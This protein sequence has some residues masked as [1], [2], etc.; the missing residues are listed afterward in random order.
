[1]SRVK[2]GN[3]FVNTNKYDNSITGPFKME[4]IHFDGEDYHKATTLS[5]WIFM[6]YDMS[7]KTFKHKSKKRRNE[8]REEFNNDTGRINYEG[9]ENYCKNV[10]K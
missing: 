9:H 1:M 7:Y 2:L 8:L 4:R 5:Q 10:C 6:K 3:K